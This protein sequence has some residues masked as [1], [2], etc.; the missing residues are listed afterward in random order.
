MSR[1][2]S[3]LGCVCATLAI[4]T[5]WGGASESTPPAESV[6]GR[7]HVLV[8]GDTIH[9]G[10][11]LRVAQKKT[12]KKGSAKKKATEPADT[13]DEATKP[14]SGND[15]E[16]KFSKDI[17]PILVGNCVGC[18]NEKAMTKNGKLDLTTYDKILK[19]AAAS[20]DSSVSPGK[21]DESHLYLRLTGEETPRMPRGGGNRRL[22]ENAVEKIGRWIKEGA[23][24]DAGIDAKAEIA[25]YAAS[26][27]QLKSDAL[28][29]L[30]VEE[31]DKLVE[32]KGIERWK[33]GNPK[34]TPE[35]T[36]GKLV[37]VF[38][39]LPKDRVTTTIRT[40]ETQYA[41]IKKMTATKDLAQKIGLYVFNDRPSF[42][43]FARSVE[44]RDVEA[45][46]QGSVDLSGSEPY[47]VV[48]DPLGGREGSA[49][50]TAKKGRA[51][52]DDSGG[53]DRSLAG[54]VTDYLANGM[55]RR[56]EKAPLWLGY[57][58][59]AY[60]GSRVDPRSPFAGRLKRNLYQQIELGWVSKAND[61]LG[62]DSK[63]E[64]IRAVGYG[65][66]EAVMGD[67]RSRP[68]STKFFTAM[69]TEGG[70]KLDDVL[71]DVL[72]MSRQEFFAW[73]NEYFTSSNQ[74]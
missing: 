51:K 26:P 62:G 61:A 22:S 60:F 36:P 30:P 66:V 21:P 41:Q 67:Q 17:A 64:D 9:G 73:T 24:L 69:S 55:I 14:A 43:E 39:N 42:V 52:R 56:S 13:G 27:E 10:R 37:T 44:N 3:V 32:S 20:G 8:A 19:A 58:L 7:T 4:A 38:G 68:V 18:H 48:I 25:S 45:T 5:D 65:I 23:K 6:E 28:S 47:I 15:G 46:E 16:L 1:I 2:L 57:G 70:E 34:G 33:K 11:I 40:V 31:R 53:P 35:V 12:R 74:Q 50:A 72:L 54:L 59:G 71:R 29:K 63:V 49:T